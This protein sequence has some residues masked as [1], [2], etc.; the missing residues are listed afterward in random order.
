MANPNQTGTILGMAPK[1]VRNWGI[2]AAVVAAL[3]FISPKKTMAGAGGGQAE[4]GG[5]EQHEWQ[6]AVR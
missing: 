2:G 3:A 6:F 5:L 4:D 1:T